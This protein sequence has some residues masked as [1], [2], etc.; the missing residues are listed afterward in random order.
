MLPF[1]TET[2]GDYK[3]VLQSSK[4]LKTGA[5]QHFSIKS[6]ASKTCQLVDEFAYRQKNILLYIYISSGF[7]EE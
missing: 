5:F 1:C 2:D 7:Y 4:C 3:A 6:E